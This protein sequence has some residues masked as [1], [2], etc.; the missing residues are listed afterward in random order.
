MVPQ[1]LRAAGT[2]FEPNPG[3]SAAATSGFQPVRGAAFQSNAIF[4]A[5]PSAATFEMASFEAA[6]AL[7]A[8]T[9]SVPAVETAPASP[10]IALKASR[11]TRPSQGSA[12]G[13]R[14]SSS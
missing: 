11:A 10:S 4:K 9:L 7:G 3:L 12:R 5:G 2:Q 13:V 6:T 8:L 1:P 14:K